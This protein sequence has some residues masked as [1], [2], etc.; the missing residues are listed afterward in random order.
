MEGILTALLLTLIAGSATGI[1]GALVLFRKKLSSNFL[2]G[3]LGLSAGVMIFISLAELYP[4]A[5]DEIMAVAPDSHGKLFVLIAFFVGMGIITLIDFLIPEYENP[6]EAPGL[7]LRDKTAAVDM[8]KHTGNAAAL[9]RLGIMSAMAIAIHNFPEGI[10]TFIGA[11]NDPEMG[12]GITFAIAIHNIPEGIAVAI[13]IYYA[14]RSKSKA[15]LYATLSG[16]SEVLGALLCLAVTSIFGIEL[17]GS[18][19][20][21]PLILSAVAGIM[22]YISLDELLPTAEKY[23][24]HHIAIAGVIAGM[25]IMSVSLLLM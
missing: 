3:A 7:S 6:H 5:Q 8:L 25:A 1:G 2:A 23:G 18:S 20:A 17:S 14:T 16:F 10:A 12:A 22:I 19:I 13:P 24:R 11:L 15:L 21:F 4:E 9:K